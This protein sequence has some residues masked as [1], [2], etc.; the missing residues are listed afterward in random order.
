MDALF[1]DFLSKIIVSEF[2]SE[3]FCETGGGDFSQKDLFHLRCVIS[4][5][6]FQG[7][8]AILP[9]KLHFLTEQLVMVL[10]P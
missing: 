7:I 1:K 3:A 6:H 2:S 10:L 9:F 5:V 8:K 4:G